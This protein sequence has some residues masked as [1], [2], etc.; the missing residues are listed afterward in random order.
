MGIGTLTNKAMEKG[1]ES[2]CK[3]RQGHGYKQDLGFILHT[4]KN[5]S[6]KET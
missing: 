1:M 4:P 6:E 3:E 2:K 5:S